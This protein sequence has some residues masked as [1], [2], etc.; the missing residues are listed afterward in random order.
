MPLNEFWH[1]G[2]DLFFAY[3]EAYLIREKRDMEQHNEKAWLS[4]LYYLSALWEVESHVNTTKE[5]RHLASKYFES[6][7]DLNGS[8][9]ANKEKDSVSDKIKERTDNSEN[10]IKLM[11]A[12]SMIALNKKKQ[13]EKKK[14]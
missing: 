4:G 14:E 9:N 11:V 7:I 1:S 5:D 12:Q 6:P 10:A 2:A 13:Q 8:N 3:R